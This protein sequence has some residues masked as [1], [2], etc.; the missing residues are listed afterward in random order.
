MICKKNYFPF[1]NYIQHNFLYDR[2][3]KIEK[4]EANLLKY[5][6]DLENK[7]ELNYE[8]IDPYLKNIQIQYKRIFN[9]AE[10]KRTDDN[11]ENKKI[12]ESRKKIQ[13]MYAFFFPLTNLD[14]LLLFSFFKNSENRGKS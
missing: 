10:N 14:K 3:F 5:L 11:Q 8:Q 12:F 4:F 2:T 1:Q 13:N 9:N 6:N 7:K